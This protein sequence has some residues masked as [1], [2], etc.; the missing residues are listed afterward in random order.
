VSKK[1]KE[2][3]N[4][5]CWMVCNAPKVKIK[6]LLLREKTNQVPFFLASVGENKKRTRWKEK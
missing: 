6:E 1:E 4:V 2:P 3:I 5:L